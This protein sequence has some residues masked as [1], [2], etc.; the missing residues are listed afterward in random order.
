VSSEPV[1]WLPA[2]LALGIG[3]VAGIAVLIR[4][5]RIRPAAAGDAGLALRDAEAERDALL[6]Q[7]REWNEPGRTRSAEAEAERREAELRAAKALRAIEGLAGSVR[8]SASRQDRGLP[9]STRRPEAGEPAGGTPALQGRRAN[10]WLGFAA[11]LGTVAAIAGVGYLA[12]G[13]AEDRAVAAPA[14]QASPAAVP[15]T[16]LPDIT[17]LENAVAADPEN[18][19]IRLEL[20][21]QLLVRDRLMEVY[22]HTEHVLR[23]H[24]DHPRA[25]TDQALVRL[26][27]G[28][29]EQALAMLD[30]ALAGDP[31]LLDAYVHKALVYATTH[32]HEEAAAVIAEAGSRYPDRKPQLEA[33]LVEMSHGH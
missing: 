6:A 33:L 28:D 30:R 4:A 29:A 5:R 12:M 7:L 15:G 14:A 22:A 3:A 1:Q 27:M 31:D 25:L 26:A 2:I 8:R 18:V 21:R 16:D 10:P 24:P 23:S 20:A 19:E 17:P 11:G 13:S 32:R 9:I